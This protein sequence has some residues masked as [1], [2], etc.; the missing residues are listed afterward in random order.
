MRHTILK[1]PNV[2]IKIP[3]MSAGILAVYKFNKRALINAHA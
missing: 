3:A 1:Q 2:M